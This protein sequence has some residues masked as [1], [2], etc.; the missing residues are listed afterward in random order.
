MKKLIFLLMAVLLIFCLVACGP[1]P[2]QIAEQMIESAYGGDVDVDIDDDGGSWSMSDGD[3][4]VSFEGDESGIAWPAD[5]FPSNVSEIQGVTVTGK[6]DAETT[7]WV[8]FEGCNDSIS[9]A[10]VQQLQN[11]G[12]DMYAE[13][14]YEGVYTAQFKIEE[15]EYITFSWSDEDG[16]GTLIYGAAE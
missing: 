7:M 9:S 1:S 10:Y 6:M 14:T 5:M 8:T 16:T 2:E 4:T 15:T 3:D 12:W 11:A 13:A